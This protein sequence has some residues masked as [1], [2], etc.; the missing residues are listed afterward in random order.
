MQGEQL[1]AKEEEE[2]EE[3]EEEEEGQRKERTRSHVSTH[4]SAQAQGRSLQRSCKVR[5]G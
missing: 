2:A 1:V 5:G 4:P 3:E